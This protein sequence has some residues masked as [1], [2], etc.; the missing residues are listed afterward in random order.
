MSISID[1]AARRAS[2]AAPKSV[3]GASGGKK[4]VDLT[5]KTELER[6][7]RDNIGIA[8]EE[9][10]DK[11]MIFNMAQALVSA[12]GKPLFS[13][14]P[15]LPY[16][17]D[18][19]MMYITGE[20]NFD[21]SVGSGARYGFLGL[22]A[23]RLP[24]P[25]LLDN[26]DLANDLFPGNNKT[27]CVDPSGRMWVYAGFLEKCIKADQTEG[28]MTLPVLN[29]EHFHVA[30][31]HCL[32]MHNFDPRISNIAKDTVINPMVKL[33][34]P[35]GTRFAKD[36]DGAWGNRPED[37]RFDGLSEETVATIMQTEA[38]AALE[39]K[40]TI[41][42]KLLEI[43]DGKVGQKIEHK[44]GKG[45]TLELDHVLITVEE[46]FNAKGVSVGDKIDTDFDAATVIIDKTINNLKMR[47]RPNQG[48]GGGSSQESVVEI[49]VRSNG[50]LNGDGKGD[51]KGGKGDRKGGKDEGEPGNGDSPS[52]GGSISGP[53]KVNPNE[54][55]GADGTGAFNSNDGHEINMAHVKEV[56]K[57]HGYGDLVDHV[58]KPDSFDPEQMQVTIETA[59]T[60]AQLERSRLGSYYP[61][62]HVDDY[63]REVVKPAMKHTVNWRQRTMEFL[64]GSG[65]IMMRSIDEQS[66][67]SL[68]EPE[69]LGMDED[70]MPVLPGLIPAKPEGR[71]AVI[72][73]S[74]GSM[75]T[76]RLVEAISLVYGIKKAGNDLSPDIDLFSADTSLRGEPIE[77]TEETIDGF[78]SNGV[79][80]FGRGGTEITGPLNQIVE[81]AKEKEVKYQ[82]ILYI[83]DFGLIAPSID[84]L[85]PELPA[86]MFLGIPADYKASAGVIKSLSEWS[87]VV[88]IDKN[89]DMNMDAAENKAS[90]RGTGVKV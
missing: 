16:L 39:E 6:R 56:L 79:S 87:E 25:I 66:T 30:L 48:G 80:V 19:M 78:I 2:P 32:R 68:L 88:C 44:A 46:L 35:A 18:K 61:G 63:M 52:E 57:K 55:P 54:E 69:D 1:P 9:G 22:L 8:T 7:Q 72:V 12:S 65:P 4:V 75:D 28:H 3:I 26:E 11:D 5:P 81:Y 40:G 73:D 71:I 85:P 45:E 62:G 49:P 33:L 64:M 20:K 13:G 58:V 76:G 24:H 23:R 51:R 82:A 53:R 36:F 42:I 47:H 90:V 84:S 74:S 37:K 83:T 27:F 60:E 86:T 15:D 89:M 38:V 21:P 14:D 31:N 50:P 17:L 10:I 41:K 29:H 70:E 43:V 77:L 59:M 34:Y 67:L